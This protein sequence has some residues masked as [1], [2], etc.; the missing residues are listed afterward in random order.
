M[1]QVDEYGRTLMVEWVNSRLD[2]PNEE[3]RASILKIVHSPI[4]RV[5]FSKPIA[6]GQTD[7]DTGDFVISLLLQTLQSQLR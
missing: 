3:T 6:G 4:V 5:H 2:G 7:F 1:G